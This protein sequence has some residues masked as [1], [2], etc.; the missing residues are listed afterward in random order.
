MDA[1][2]SILIAEDDEN[3]A[4]IV[5]R[6][7]QEAGVNCP[8]HF[9]KDGLEARAFLCGEA[10]YVDR[11]QFNSPWLLIT[12]LK[13]PRMTGLE[14]L[15]WLRG[16]AECGLIPTIVLSASG[17]TS[18]IQ[19]AYRLGAN[20]YLVKPSSYKDLVEAMRLI[21]GYWGICAKPATLPAWRPGVLTQQVQPVQPD[22]PA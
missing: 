9:C 14:L 17:Q 21:V 20:S 15:K 1:E 6:A 12:D 3:D 16:H 8:V 10:P 18:D 19:E 4:F 5:K 13:M 7:L 2:A 11:Q 22:Q